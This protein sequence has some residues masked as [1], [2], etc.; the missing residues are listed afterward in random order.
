M[1]RMDYYIAQNH[2]TAS[3]FIGQSSFAVKYSAGGRVEFLDFPGPIRFNGFEP[4]TCCER[5]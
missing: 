3:K 1:G 4:F 5:S 2:E